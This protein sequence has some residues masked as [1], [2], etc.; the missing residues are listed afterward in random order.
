MEYTWTPLNNHQLNKYGTRLVHRFENTGE[1]EEKIAG[2]EGAANRSFRAK[3]SIISSRNNSALRFQRACLVSDKR[4]R[5]AY[6]QTFVCLSFDK[7]SLIALVWPRAVHVRFSF[8]FPDLVATFPILSQAIYYDHHRDSIRKISP[9]SRFSF[10][11]PLCINKNL[12]VDSRENVE[13]EY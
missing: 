6:K 1:G 9:R 7:I 12:I 13:Y 5:L 3:C 10:S 2:R 4:T 11:F 8:A